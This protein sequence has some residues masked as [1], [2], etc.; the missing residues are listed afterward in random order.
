MDR[1]YFMEQYISSN[2]HCIRCEADAWRDC[3]GTKSLGRIFT[4]ADSLNYSRQFIHSHF[5]RGCAGLSCCFSLCFCV[6]W[7]TP[8]DKIFGLLKK[9]FSLITRHSRY[10]FWSSNCA[11]SLRWSVAVGND[12][13]RWELWHSQHDSLPSQVICPSWLS[14][15]TRFALTRER[16]SSSSSRCCSRS[17]DEV[18]VIKSKQPEFVICSLHLPQQKTLS[19]KF[20]FCARPKCR[21]PCAQKFAI[22][23]AILIVIILAIGFTK[24]AMPGPSSVRISNWV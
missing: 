11:P 1:K 18:A 4:I 12:V 21:S 7:V 20:S 9:K 17:I 19:S 16:H 15:C 24:L 22:L 3:D 2:R 5:L 6:L 10:R 13:S 8:L 23:T 14:T